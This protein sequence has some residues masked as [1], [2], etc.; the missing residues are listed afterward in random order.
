MHTQDLI[1]ETLYIN[2]HTYVHNLY[3]FLS[4]EVCKQTNVRTAIQRVR[5]VSRMMRIG[6]HEIVPFQS[7]RSSCAHGNGLP[8]QRRAMLCSA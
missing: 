8:P 6:A 2:S 1:Y 4:I 5:S 7:M 3:V